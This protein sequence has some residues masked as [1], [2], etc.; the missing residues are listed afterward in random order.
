[1]GIPKQSLGMRLMIYPSK[2]LKFMRIAISIVLL[3]YITTLHFSG[4]P[5]LYFFVKED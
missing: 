5:G 1:M 3:S 2:K 4:E